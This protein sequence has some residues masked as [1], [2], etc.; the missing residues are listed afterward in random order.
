MPCVIIVQAQTSIGLRLGVNLATWYSSPKYI[1]VDDGATLTEPLSLGRA[2][3]V[4]VEFKLTD[5]FAIQS[6]LSYMQKGYT[7]V[8]S[9]NS[10]EVKVFYQCNYFEL[11]ILF[12][13][14]FGSE[15]FKIGV[16]AGPSFNYLNSVLASQTRK[17]NGNTDSSTREIDLNNSIFDVNRFDL[18]LVLGVQP[19]YHI[20]E[21]G[22]IFFDARYELGF[23]NVFKDVSNNSVLNLCLGLSL[24]YMHTLGEL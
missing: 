21:R 20:G 14:T 12:K 22:R 13:T 7:F 16:L 6:E 11:P 5:K 9:Y 19:T 4:A 8:S 24:G 10:T 15:K 3:A 18:G 23:L 2:I 1:M 17:S